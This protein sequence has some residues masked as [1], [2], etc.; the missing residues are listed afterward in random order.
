MEKTLNLLNPWWIKKV[1][2]KTIKRDKYL[3]IIK[4]NL[5]NELILF[6]TGLRRVGKTTLIK[7]T[8]NY[9][10]N[11]LKIN[12]KKILFLNLDHIEFMNSN[13]HNLIDKYRELNEIKYDEFIYLFLDEVTSK[14]NFEQE[15]KNIF[16]IGNA[17]IICSSSI[18]SL[19]SDKKA[20]LTGRTKTIEVFPLD[21]K[22]YL[23]FKKINIDKFDNNMNKVWFERYLSQGG[24]PEFVLREDIDYLNELLNSIIYKDI[25]GHYNIKNEK[26]IKELL[27]LLCQRIG[28]PTSYN[29]LG[30]I[31]GLNGDTIK[32]Y[33]NYFEK[34]YLFYSVEKYS[35]SINENITSPKKF[36]IADL[37][38]KKIISSNKELGVDFENLVFLK[39]KKENPKYYLKEG[40]EIDFCY[41][42]TLIE[43]KY[44]QEM[45]NKQK[46]LFNKLNFKNKI[47]IS[48]YNYF[49]E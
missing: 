23:Q 32:R 33:I 37:G 44:N 1:E 18:A 48:D 21:F 9:L 27:R 49:L 17:K 38:L 41:K 42:D 14:D 8:I 13:I 29:K 11:E 31:L 15:L 5:D 22:E 16:D 36:Y 43:A 6:I 24:I 40:I 34:S 30:K 20:Y 46:E 3:D 47:I 2:E 35:K 26:E 7:Q 19:M 28:K 4:Q 10:I 25:I 45:N 12:S 39:I